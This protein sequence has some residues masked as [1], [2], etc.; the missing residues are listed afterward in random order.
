MLLIFRYLMCFSPSNNR[1]GSFTRSYRV[2]DSF[3]RHRNN[4]NIGG[5]FQERKLIIKRFPTI[6]LVFEIFL[7]IRGQFLPALCHHQKSFHHSAVA[8]ASCPQNMFIFNFHSICNLF[9]KAIFMGHKTKRFWYFIARLVT[10]EVKSKRLS[11][12]QNYAIIDYLCSRQSEELLSRRQSSRLTERQ[13]KQK[14]NQGGKRENF[15]WNPSH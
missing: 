8:A 4:W 9:I 7:F 5:M 3:L 1:A 15:P 10:V 14:K 11:L 13:S 6:N 2:L 12:L